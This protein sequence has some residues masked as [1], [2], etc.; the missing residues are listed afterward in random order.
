MMCRSALS[1]V[2]TS[3]D[4]NSSRTLILFNKQ[5]R[6]CVHAKFLACLSN[7]WIDQVCMSNG[8]I[9]YRHSASNL[10]SFA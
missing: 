10:A 7:G 3:H 2:F 4:Y 1:N 8:L 6:G 9:F 5:V